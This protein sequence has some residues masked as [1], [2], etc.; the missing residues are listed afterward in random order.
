MVMHL[1]VCHADMT[2]AHLT[3]VNLTKR[4]IPEHKSDAPHYTP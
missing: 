3:A 2:R 4:G 1:S